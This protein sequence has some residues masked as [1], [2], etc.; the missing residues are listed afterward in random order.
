MEKAE[1]VINPFGVAVRKRLIELGMT[2][3]ELSHEIK[4]NENYLICILNGSRSGHKYKPLI[5]ERL[6]LQNYDDLS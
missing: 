6:G 4:C 3:R 1:R 2:Q 5:I